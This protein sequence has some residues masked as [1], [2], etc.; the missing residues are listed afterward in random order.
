MLK[1]LKTGAVRASPCRWAVQGLDAGH[2]SLYENACHRLLPPQEGASLRLPS[3]PFACLPSLPSL[4]LP[5]P[6]F[7]SVC[8]SWRQ[9]A[10]VWF[11]RPK[12][13][14][15]GPLVAA[16]ASAVSSRGATGLQG[17]SSCG[18]I[19][20][21]KSAPTWPG[22]AEVLE[23]APGAGGVHSSPGLRGLQWGVWSSA[24]RRSRRGRDRDRAA[25]PGVRQAPPKRA[26]ESE[27]ERDAARREAREAEIEKEAA[28]LE[29]AA[30][31]LLGT[32]CRMTWF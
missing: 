16:S 3:P 4:I 24:M 12:R 17:A 26:Q 13:A 32:C 14:G 29:T 28:K 23:E 30:S 8:V 10:S 25:N 9:L 20:Q 31:S 2:P 27:S 19:V 7:A 6:P 22:T 15:T 1:D 21:S 5:S 18:F 11:R